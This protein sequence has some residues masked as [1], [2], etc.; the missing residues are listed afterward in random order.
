MFPTKVGEYP[1]PGTILWLF[2]TDGF[3][4]P[5]TE[6][7]DV[8]EVR[9]LKMTQWQFLIQKEGD[10]DWLP[11]ETP[12]AEILEGRYRLVAQVDCPD[13]AV[14]VHIRYE[15]E[16][17]GI[18]QEIIQQRIQQPNNDGYIELFGLNYLLP[19]LWDLN[20]QVLSDRADVQK[21]GRNISLQVLSQ[22]FELLSEWDPIDASP[23]PAPKAHGIVSDPVPACNN[24][25]KTPSQKDCEIVLLPAIPK[26]LPQVAFLISDKNRL[27]PL[28]FA[29]MD[30]ETTSLKPQ[31]PEFLPLKTVLKEPIEELEEIPYLDFL[32]RIAK[33][34]DRGS[35]RG[36]FE[37][38]AWNQRFWK[39]LNTLAT[40]SS[41][42]ITP[43][44]SLVY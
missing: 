40:V 14:K 31:L 23:T 21:F 44:E 38:L 33:S 10:R 18:L 27:P 4:T 7:C 29:P 41:P 42:A 1:S 22:D 24:T 16:L 6:W 36:D 28:L 20:C 3:G 5:R 43:D 34:T 9:K 2:S 30:G 17:D 13:L 12:G 8:C 35:V 39:T 26:E 11:L 25:Q 19:G 37:S 15:Y 32:R